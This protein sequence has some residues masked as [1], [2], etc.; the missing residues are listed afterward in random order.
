MLKFNCE[1]RLLKVYFSSAYAEHVSCFRSVAQLLRIPKNAP[2]PFWKLFC[3]DC[4]DCLDCTDQRLAKNPFLFSNQSFQA[5]FKL[6]NSAFCRFTAS[7]MY[8]HDW[9]MQYQHWTNYFRL[10][11]HFHSL[12][13]LDTYKTCFHLQNKVTADVARERVRE[14]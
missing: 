2:L 4:T 6:S 14:G 8:A 3:T 13:V 7:K 9:Q 11:M 10:N 1:A 12:P 5:F